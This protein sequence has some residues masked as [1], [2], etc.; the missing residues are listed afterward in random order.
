[1]ICKPSGSDGSGDQPILG[2]MTPQYF[3]DCFK[4]INIRSINFF[5]C[6]SRKYAESFVSVYSERHRE[7][8]SYSYYDDM[9]SPWPASFGP[10]NPLQLYYA[11]PEIGVIVGCK[12]LDASQ[13]KPIKESFKKINITTVKKKVPTNY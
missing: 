5:S 7:L 11:G 3:S 12:K 1:M 6:L 10:K 9:V 4:C 13:H 8:K 2:N